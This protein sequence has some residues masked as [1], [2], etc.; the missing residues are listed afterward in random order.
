MIISRTP[1]RIS[2]FGGGS[3]FPAHYRYY[4]GKVIS[5]AINKYCYLEVRHLPPFFS[6]KHRIVY[7]RIENVTEFSE[8]QHPA[9]KA[10]LEYLRPSS[11]ISIIHDGD[12]PA[13]SGIGSS[14]AFTVGLLNSLWHLLG[15]KVCKR[16]LAETAIHIEQNIIKETV[17]SQDQ[18]CCAYGGFNVIRFL[19][20]GSFTLTP[21]KL[22]PERMADFQQHLLLI[23]TGISRISSEV[24]AEQHRKLPE[25]VSRLQQLCAFADQAEEL[26]QNSSDW[27]TFGELMHQSWLIKRSL[28]DRISSAVLDDIY[29]RARAAGALGGKLLGAGAGGFML[30]L[31]PPEK[32][33]AII[34]ALPGLLPVPFLFDHKG[35]TIIFAEK[36]EYDRA[37]ILPADE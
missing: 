18:I 25:N 26:L 21:L 5:A 19:T 28:S 23:Y 30:F 10:V 34:Q 31:A 8:I 32:H 12:I 9:V 33:P 36:N 11:G 4:G 24:A 6:H 17:G 2:F 1:F 20:D 29:C 14:S 15:I 27:R 3:D 22:S 37:G 16:Q 13:R 35:S 7:S